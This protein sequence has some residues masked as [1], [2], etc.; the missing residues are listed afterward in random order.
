MQ[1]RRKKSVVKVI[2]IGMGILIFV[3]LFLLYG[4]WDLVRTTWITTAM[5]TKNHQYLAT[6]LYRDETIEKVLEENQVVE[7][8]VSSDPN[9]IDM[10]TSAP[11]TAYEKQILDREQPEDLFKVLSVR[12]KGYRGTLVVIYHPEK[13]QLATASTLGQK[14][15][16]IDVV[17]KENNAHVAINASGFYDPD[18][19]GNGGIPH[20]TVIKNGQ[21]VST[22]PEAPVGGGFIGFTWDHKLVLGKM[23]VEEALE[24]GYR[25]AIEFG[26]FLIVNG[27]P[28]FIKGN[29]GW[30]IAPRT[31]IGQRKDGI[32]LFLVIDGRTVSS[33]GADMLDLTKIMERYGAYNAANLD[34]GSSTELWIDGKIVN[35]PVGNGKNGLRAMPTFWIVTD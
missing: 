20:G 24:L 23:S 21:V 12:G 33:I 34:G 18:T 26:P 14:G 6:W 30:G 17:A 15:E 29:G 31:A 10:T 22:Y 35:T 1:K 27:Q 9:L 5:T 7:G 2:G 4:P 32:V 19:K 8:D 13:V 28:S 11:T 16:T 3:V 25:D